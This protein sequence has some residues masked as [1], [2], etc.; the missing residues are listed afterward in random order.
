MGNKHFLNIYFATTLCALSVK[1][2]ELSYRL[3]LKGNEDQGRTAH[4]Q[5]MA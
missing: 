3:I 2:S 1:S 5:S 4:T